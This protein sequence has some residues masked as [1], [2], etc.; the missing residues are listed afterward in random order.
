MSNPIPAINIHPK[1]MFLL[2]GLG[3]LSSFLLLG[4]VLPE[5]E[6][7][8]GVTMKHLFPLSTIAGVYCIYSM[9]CHFLITKN[10]TPYLITIAIANLF[11]C[12]IT[13][14]LVFFII[15]S[16]TLIGYIYFSLEILVITILVFVEFQVALKYK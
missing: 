6:N 7:S 9:L 8:M 13:A 10:W 16:V 12:L 11:Y 14:V 1:R 5:F 2:D 4:I 3:A 15:D